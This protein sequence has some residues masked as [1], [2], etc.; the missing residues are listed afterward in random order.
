MLAL[1]FY[2]LLALLEGLLGNPRTLQPWQAGGCWP[3]M[4]V[5]KGPNSGPIGSL[6]S[7]SPAALAGSRLLA[8]NV[9]VVKGPNSS[10]IGSLLSSLKN[11]NPGGLAVIRP[12]SVRYPSASTSW[13]FVS[14]VC[15][16]LPKAALPSRRFATFET[17][18]LCER[19]DHF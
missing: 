19:G 10:P 5:V 14:T 2:S 15:K 13:C 16:F 9:N 6:Q 3:G 7:S 17:C 11:I 1:S 8:G 4:I 12:L 18:V